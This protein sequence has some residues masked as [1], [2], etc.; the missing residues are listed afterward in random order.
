MASTASAPFIQSWWFSAGLG[1]SRDE[2]LDMC[3]LLGCDFASK[4]PGI[5][6]K[7]APKLIKAHKTIEAV[8]QS[9]DKT[10][11]G[12][13]DLPEVRNL[14]KNPPVTDAQ[15]LNLKWDKPDETGLIKFL[16]D[17]AGMGEAGA[18]QNAQKLFKL[19]EVILFEALNEKFVSERSRRD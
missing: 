4:I 17:K 12:N 9:L 19:F 2:F 8:L 15:R 11:P 13:F 16:S 5:G 10:P 3:I 7:K 6:A 1:R 14:F 18:K